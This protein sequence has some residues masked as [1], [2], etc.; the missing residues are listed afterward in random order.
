MSQRWL[1]VQRMAP[2]NPKAL[3]E[4]IM[5][6]AHAP[7]RYDRERLRQFVLD[8]YSKPVVADFVKETY[9]NAIAQ[10]AT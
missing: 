7:Q 5:Q 10:K 8:H 1:P 3:A 6:V 4:E 9:V 2:N